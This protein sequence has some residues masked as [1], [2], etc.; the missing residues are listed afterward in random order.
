MLQ[1]SKINLSPLVASVAV[2]SKEV[3]LLLLIHCLSLLGFV[4]GPCF[5][6]KCLV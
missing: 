6:L 1:Y 3:V 5:E 2:H 4:F